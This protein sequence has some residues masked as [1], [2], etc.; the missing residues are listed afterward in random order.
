MLMLFFASSTRF[1]AARL[2]SVRQDIAFPSSLVE[3]IAS[4]LAQP[5]RPVILAQQIVTML[6]AVRLVGSAKPTSLDIC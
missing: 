6:D 1:K 2:C 4:M 3:R 5:G